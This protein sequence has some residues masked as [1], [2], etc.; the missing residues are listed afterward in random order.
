MISVNRLPVNQA[1]E[2]LLFSSAHAEPSPSH[3]EQRVNT[4]LIKN[5]SLY[6]SRCKV[7]ANNNGPQYLIMSIC[8]IKSLLEWPVIR[9]SR[10]CFTH[11]PR[12][13]PA[14]LALVRMFVFVC[15]LLVS[16]LLPAC[17]SRLLPVA[18]LS[19]ASCLRFLGCVGSRIAAA[20]P[21]LLDLHQISIF[22]EK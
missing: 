17:V 20:L 21:F 16:R 1:V 2:S 12:L 10:V 22:F 11:V 5:T 9:S 4:N 15:V 19:S 13:C 18:Y 14:H 7:T 6:I 3:T 8:V